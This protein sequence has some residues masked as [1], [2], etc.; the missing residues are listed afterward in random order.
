M[1]IVLKFTYGLNNKVKI[2]F[3]TVCIL[4]NVHFMLST[5]LMGTNNGISFKKI[6]FQQWVRI[7]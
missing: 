4:W 7:I 5:I 3:P 1:Q 2:Q 6:L